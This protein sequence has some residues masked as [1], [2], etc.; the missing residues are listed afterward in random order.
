MTKK[1]VFI[2]NC[3]CAVHQREVQTEEHTCTHG[4]T[5]TYARTWTHSNECNWREFNALHFAYKQAIG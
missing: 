2:S 3:F 4:D 1:G 5:R